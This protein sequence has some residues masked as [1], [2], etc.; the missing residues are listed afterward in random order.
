MFTITKPKSRRPGLQVKVKCKPFQCKNP[1]TL[2]YYPESPLSNFNC[3]KIDPL[4]FY[5]CSICSAIISLVLAELLTHV[6]YIEVFSL[7]PRLFNPKC[8]RSR[9]LFH[10]YATPKSHTKPMLLNQ[11]LILTKA[12]RPVYP[13]CNQPD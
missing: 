5:L 10:N 9:F 13:Y 7:T 4:P 11:T 6:F 2:Q 12:G 8:E 3:L 1:V